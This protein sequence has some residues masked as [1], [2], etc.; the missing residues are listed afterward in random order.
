MKFCST[1]TVILHANLGPLRH[2]RR[3]FI[4]VSAYF[5]YLYILE[6]KQF[7]ITASSSL[8]LIRLGGRNYF[9]SNNQQACIPYNGFCVISSIQK[10]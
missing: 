7:N 8:N 9:F 6:I 2:I 5:V 4:S 3:H 10:Y 1:L